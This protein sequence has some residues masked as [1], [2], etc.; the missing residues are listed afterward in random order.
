MPS[1][2][3]VG[4]F[5]DRALA[6]QAIEALYRAGFAHD[7]IRFASPSGATGSFFQDLKSLFTGPSTAA[8]NIAGDL[9]DM[10][11]SDDEAHYYANE[12]ANGNTILAVQSAEREQEVLGILYQYGAYN[13]RKSNEVAESAPSDASTYASSESYAPVEPQASHSEEPQAED[14]AYP[15]SEQPVD[16]AYASPETRVEEAPAYHSSSPETTYDDTKVSDDTYHTSSP[17]E[18]R[19]VEESAPV[20]ATYTDTERKEEENKPLDTTYADTEPKEEVVTPGEGTEYQSSV[21]TTDANGEVKQ[22]DAPEYQAPVENADTEEEVRENENAGYTSPAGMNPHTSESEPVEYQQPEAKEAEHYIQDV[23]YNNAESATS[24][25]NTEPNLEASAPEASYTTEPNLETSA[26]ESR[27]GTEPNLESSAD[28]LD[29]DTEPNLA[30]DK[31]EAQPATWGGAT[32]EQADGSSADHASQLSGYQEQLRVAKQRLEE[33]KSQLQRAKD[34]E[35]QLQAVKQELEAVQAEL[36]S[37]MSQL[38]E[39]HTRIAQYR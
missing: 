12:Y 19:V 4:V 37:T 32:D 8:S 21:E 11:L 36:D 38:K 28:A 34:H 15:S 20:D 25:Y 13:A 3:T 31:S 14:H 33:A 7:T 17:V 22:V 16:M 29:Y 5:R 35:Q 6:E 27:Y 1:S 18:D 39:T 9:T 23:E 24:R 2:T 26:T 30:H 10:G